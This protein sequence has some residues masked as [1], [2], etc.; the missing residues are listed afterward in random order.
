M[1]VAKIKPLNVGNALKD[2][3]NANNETLVRNEGA[4]KVQYCEVGS[5]DN[6][7]SIH[8]GMI[9]DDLHASNI[10][11]ERATQTLSS[12][13]SISSSEQFSPRKVEEPVPFLSSV[14]RDRSLQSK[15]DDNGK[16]NLMANTTNPNSTKYETNSR[17]FRRVTLEGPIQISTDSN[18]IVGTENSNV[19]PLGQGLSL[20]KKFQFYNQFLDSPDG[21]QSIDRNP[22]DEIVDSP[23]SSCTQSIQDTSIEAKIQVEQKLMKIHSCGLSNVVV[24]D[25]STE[26]KSCD[27][28]MAPDDAL[29]GNLDKNITSTKQK[30]F[31]F[32]D[33][34]VIH[35]QEV[36]VDL[37]DID[38]DENDSN[39]DP[40]G[41]TGYVEWKGSMETSF[42]Q[43]TDCSRGQK[44][45]RH[46]KAKSSIGP[47]KTLRYRFG[48]N[49]SERSKPNLLMKA[50]QRQER[51]A[52]NS[53]PNLSSTISSSAAPIG[54]LNKRSSL[55]DFLKKS[56]QKRNAKTVLNENMTL[57]SH[58]PRQSPPLA[59]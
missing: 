34:P 3:S 13:E 20:P 51:L 27:T 33:S 50:F 31:K 43:R 10:E 44:E 11:N 7:S 59:K 1:S 54:K 39:Y 16:K 55:A 28:F 47:A 23:E 17:Y 45:Q 36:M 41:R 35:E 58:F 49:E 19:G 30:Y 40:D 32:Y 14:F 21:R 48:S 5:S 52:I 53:E 26:Q 24:A 57:L 6:L 37:T 25:N 4:C 15:I 38:G 56:K 9:S 8:N 18:S 22:P 42:S 46:P 12:P 2:S 29:G